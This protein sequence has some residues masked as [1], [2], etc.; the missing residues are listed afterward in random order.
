MSRRVVWLQ[1]LIGWFPVW[2]L[3]TT[4][5]VTAHA[6]ASLIVAAGIALRMILSGALLSIPVHKAVVR[7]PWPRPMRVRFVALHLVLAAIYAHAWVL[8]NSA[9]ESIL[10]G[11]PVLTVGYTLASFLLLG[12]WLY[13]MIVGVSYSSLATER[14]ASAEANAARSKLAVLRSQLHPHFLFNALHSV[15]QLIPS[16]PRRAAQ[17]AEELASLLRGTIE[18]DRDLVPAEEEWSFVERYLDLERMRFGDRLR[19]HV[20]LSAEARAAEIPLFALQTLV[21]N[22][23]RHAA[24]PRVEPTEITVTGVATDGRVTFTVSDTG[25]GTT[26]DQVD[27]S[28]GTGL[29]RLRERLA[30]L[31]GTEG[32]LQVQTAEGRGFS[33][34]LTI[35]HTVANG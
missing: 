18:E 5:I 10:R 33:V 34:T 28:A 17:A 9:I 24:A 16:D 26:P 35:P 11:R 27:K 4:L 1:L 29:R 22:A 30:A 23:V 21:E 32:S 14:A 20:D 19:V 31:Y 3:F 8:V 25:A 7:L 2:A 12:V 13:V 15:V 6:N